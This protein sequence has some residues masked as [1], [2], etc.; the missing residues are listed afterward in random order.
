MTATTE[1]EKE[2]IRAVASLL[3]TA[4]KPLRILRTLAWEPE[5]KETFLAQGGRELP[6]VTY[7]AFDPT[8][9]IEAVREARRQ[10]V[11]VTTI[12]LWLDRQANAIELSA[13]MLAAVGTAGFFEY[14]RQLYGEPTAPLRYVPITPLDLA[15]SVLDTIAN[16]AHIEMHTAPPSDHTA[17]SVAAD[18]DVAVRAHFGDQAPAIELVDRLS[19]N[20]LATSRAIRIRRGAR[21]TDRDCVQLL[22]HEAY[23]HVATSLN[24]RAQTDLPLLAAGHPGTTRTQEGLAVFAE[25]ISG[26][27]ELDR[28]R[29][30]ADRVLAIQMAIDGADFLEVYRYYLER[31]GDPDQAFENARRVFRGG[32]ITGGAP[33]TK[34]LVYL[35]GLLQVDNF[36]RAGF[37]AGRADCLSLLFCGKL[38]LFDIPALCELYALGLCRPPR[39]LPP[40]I[41]DPRHLLALLTFSVFTSRISLEPIVEVARKLLD[42][43]PMVRMP[44]AGET[45][46]T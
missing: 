28:L 45:F 41:S 19:A 32:V 40:W 29:R 20:A 3:H 35:L 4:C 17:E 33:F 39:F 37:A 9:S 44:G 43:A 15:Q 5:V 30:L 12:D 22:H 13:R 31:T 16:L 2:R 42:S 36:I 6:Q 10:I 7:P 25:V 23:I 27:I 21:F 26:S 1:R 34:D 14:G 38:D 24:G 46:P 18:L 8:S 11:P